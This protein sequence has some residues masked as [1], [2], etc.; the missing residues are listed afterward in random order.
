[1]RLETQI[2]KLA[3]LGLSLNRGITVDDFL[4][5]FPREE[6]EEDPFE[7]ILFTYGIEVEEQPWGRFF[8]DRV[9]N[10]DAECICDEGDYTK[11]VEEFHRISG[12]R[13]S[14]IDL[15][16]Q[17]DLE[18][19]KATLQFTIDGNHREFK[20]RIDNDWVDPDVASAIMRDMRG[21]GFDFYGLDN[22][23]STVWFYMT[24]EN[25]ISLNLL[26]GNVFGLKQKPWW[27]IW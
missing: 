22:G 23:Q 14:L 11:I 21:E 8:C 26:A 6:Y 25:A 12:K 18:A 17:I 9:W 20:P 16:D 13:K 3:E 19:G 5:S 24:S 7:A 15:S 4:I 10:F 2:E 1:M 27:K